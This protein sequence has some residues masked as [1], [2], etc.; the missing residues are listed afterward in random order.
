MRR[1]AFRAVALLCVSILG[2]SCGTAEKQALQAPKG[3]TM[4]TT[5]SAD[6]GQNVKLT[7][8]A[9]EAFNKKDYDAAIGAA[10]R[11]INEFL[12]R[13]LRE[14][15]ELETKRGTSVPDRN[16]LEP[17]KADDQFPRFAQR[18]GYVPVYQGPL[19]RSQAKKAGAVT[20]YEATAKFTYA[21]CWDP[22]G[23]FWSLSEGAQDRLRML[24]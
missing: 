16:S 13:A 3:Q 14:Q 12:G 24:K 5:S 23:W 21:R 1:K 2:L 15:E 20:A 4:N 6:A 17:G 22:Q 8:E 18:C 10:D 7:N 9:W 11:C 19:T